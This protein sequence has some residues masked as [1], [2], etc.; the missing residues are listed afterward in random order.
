MPTLHPASA[1]PAPPVRR[2]HALDEPRPERRVGLIGTVAAHALLLVLLLTLPEDVLEVDRVSAPPE[3]TRN[4]EIEL[5][6]ELFNPPRPVF[7]PPQFVEVNP[8]A[9]ENVPDKTPFVGAQNQQ[10]A[11]PVPTPDG[12]SDTPAAE[13][14]GE[15]GATALVSGQLQETPKPSLAEQLAQAFA[16]PTPPSI[17]P[18]RESP[19][20]EQVPAQAINGLGGGEQLLGETDGATG[21]TVTALPKV[22]GAE[23][24][25]EPRRGTA[26]ARAATGG[27]FAGTPAIDR[28]TP[29]ERPQL[30]AATINARNT[31]TIK[32][33]FGTKNI[34]GV[35]YNAKWSS[36][37]EYL[38][39]LI[40]A[41]QGQWERLIMRSAYYPVSG[42]LVRVVFKLN[43]KGEISEIVSVSGGGG[44][45]AQRL[46][47]SA[48]SERAPYGDWSDDMR[49]AL[50]AEQ[51]LGFTFFY[52]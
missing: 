18:E 12:A 32:N 13:G 40:D 45:L 34:G 23:S 35:S 50:G 9:P 21:T 33:E 42:S 51:E 29:Q 38:Q 5:A 8:S 24:G 15:A 52:Q 16:P 30:T 41:V 43:A 48:I 14:T 19:P 10:V 26:E 44:E 22:P 36:Y 3:V 47:V 28:N 46:C 7:V 49:A 31:P 25:A 2:T 20:A 39:R 4:F 17:L 1:P 6:P 27:Y 37:G 11:Q